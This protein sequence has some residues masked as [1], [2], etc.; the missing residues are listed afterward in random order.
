MTVD[1]E[2]RQWEVEIAAE[3]DAWE[4]DIESEARDAATWEQERRQRFSWSDA[5]PRA[6]YFAPPKRCPNYSAAYCMAHDYDHVLE[7]QEEPMSWAAL[8]N[9]AAAHEREQ[10]ASAFL[11]DPY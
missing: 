3:L 4:Q 2:L 1:T 6:A 8:K 7:R 5:Q 9:E 10:E 11:S